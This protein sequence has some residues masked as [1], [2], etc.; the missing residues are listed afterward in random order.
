MDP[1]GRTDH[2]R[3][4]LLAP[5][6]VAGQTRAAHRGRRVLRRL[7]RPGHVELNATLGERVDVGRGDQRLAVA[8]QL[9]AQV[10]R[11]DEQDV[12]GRFGLRAAGFVGRRASITASGVSSRA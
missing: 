5:R 4:L 10:V 2:H 8:P 7:G 6:G 3:P 9:Q 12:Q 11:D 1:L